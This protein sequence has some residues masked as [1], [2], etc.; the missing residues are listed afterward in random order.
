MNTKK[1][2]PNDKLQKSSKLF[3]QLG[4]IAALLFTYVVIEYQ[5]I[6]KP[7]KIVETIDTEP[8][9]YSYPQAPT[10]IKYEPEK[11]VIK[12]KP[13]TKVPLDDFK[14]IDNDTEVVT[15]ILKPE[16]DIPVDIDAAI[17]SLPPDNTPDTDDDEVL[18]FIRLEQA[19]IFPGC[20]GLDKEEAKLCFT[21]AISRFVNKKF[22][23]GL[24]EQLGLDG[25]QKIY[26]QFIIDKTGTDTDIIARAPHKA[27]EKEAI[28]IV[29]KLPQMTPGKQRTR[30]V[31]VKYTL[32][33]KFEVYQ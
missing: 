13:K 30:P 19:P 32:P 31:S 9:V 15:D 16:K 22:N 26:V 11:K 3:M 2:H 17:K 29:K 18:P 12:V 5:S 25:K 28:R 6:K 27:L 20:E 8:D 24:G 21:K 23:T 33:I 1:Q 14:K 4:L 7:F 10:V